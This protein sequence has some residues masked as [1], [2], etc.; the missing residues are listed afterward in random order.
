MIRRFYQTEERERAYLPDYGEYDW[1][2]L[3]R[4]THLEPFSYPVWDQRH[5]EESRMKERPAQDCP[6]AEGCGNQKGGPARRFFVLFDYRKRDPL[7]YEATAR[8]VRLT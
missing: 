1:K 4:M 2:Q 6:T 3:A 5:M 8:P 7:T